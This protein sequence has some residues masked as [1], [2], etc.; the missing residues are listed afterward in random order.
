MRNVEE[1]LRDARNKG[2]ILAN[3]FE[4]RTHPAHP[5]IPSTGTGEFQANF[6]HANGWY[7]YGRGKDPAEALEDAFQRAKG[8]KGAENRPI[9]KDAPLKG[10]EE[11]PSLDDLI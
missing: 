11:K 5:N 6:H 9:P 7:D 2:L 1:I 3:L 10:R 8:L 4:L